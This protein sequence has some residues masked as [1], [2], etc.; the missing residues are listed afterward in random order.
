MT[1]KR[2]AL[3]TLAAC[4]IF[5]AS[6]AQSQETKAVNTFG[7]WTLYAHT[8]EPGD[9]CFITS[10]PRETKPTDV[11]RDRAYFYVSSWAKDGIRNQ[12]SVLLGYDLKD[13]DN[14]TIKIGSSDFE[15]FAKDDKGF[16]GDSTNELQLIDAMKR[17]NFMT[18]NA[19]MQDGTETTDTY[20]LIG[21]T[22]AMNAL[23]SGCS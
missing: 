21:A 18:V 22:A 4:A 16:V 13:Q 14:I 20:S 1:L 9:I 8:G 3:A 7:A 11:E 6:N 12:V 23:N 5:L 2:T 17:G 19:K 10:Q 15:L